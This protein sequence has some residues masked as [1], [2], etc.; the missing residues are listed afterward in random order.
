MEG[1][2]GTMLYGEQHSPL[3]MM[4]MEEVWRNI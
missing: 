1:G 4:A 3:Y 2:T